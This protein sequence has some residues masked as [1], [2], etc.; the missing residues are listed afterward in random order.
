[1]ERF[2]APHHVKDTTSE[3]LKDALYGILDRHMLSISRLKGQGYDK[4]SNMR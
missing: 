2:V 1:V 3:A 4:V